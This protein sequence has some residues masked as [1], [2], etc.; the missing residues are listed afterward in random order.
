MPSVAK[1]TLII[2]D[3]TGDAG[4]RTRVLTFEGVEYEIDLT[5]ASFADLRR[6]LKPYLKAARPVRAPRSGAPSSPPADSSGPARRAS[7]SDS[8][9]DSATIRAWAR[10]TGVAVPERGRIPATVRASWIEAGSPR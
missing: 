10:S 7:R 9:S 5:D 4:A 1:K 2:D 3:L 8:G 6:L